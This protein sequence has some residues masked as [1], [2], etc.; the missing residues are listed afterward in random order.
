MNKY[1]LGNQSFNTW[2]DVKDHARSMLAKGARILTGNDLKFAK[3]LL[4]FHPHKRKKKRDG[5]STIKVGYPE[6]PAVSQYCCF[7]IVDAKGNEQDFSYKKCSPRSIKNRDKVINSIENRSRLES[8]RESVF[9]QVQKAGESLFANKS[10][11]SC[12]GSNVKLQIDHKSKSFI[13]IVN[14]F[15][16]SYKPEKYP[17]IERCDSVHTY[18]FKKTRKI[19]TAFIEAWQLFHDNQADYQ[20]LCSDCNLKKQDGVRYRPYKKVSET[21]EV[22]TA[23]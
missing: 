16:L 5:V 1:Q 3:D 2:E 8:Y 22:T 11:C 20:I 13:S 15:E 17:T 23:A 4:E 14:Q 18:R 21:D 6:F 7:V 10:A 12:C 19:F 9:Y